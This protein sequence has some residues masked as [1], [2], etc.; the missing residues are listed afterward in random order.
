MRMAPRWRRRRWIAIGGATVAVTVGLWSTIASGAPSGLAISQS[1]VGAAPHLSWGDDGANGAA[2]GY[3]VERS[4]DGCTTFQ[5]AGTTATTTFDDTPPNS[6]TWCYHVIGHYAG[7]L[8][9]P[10]TTTATAVFDNAPPTVQITSPAAGGFAHGKVTITATAS[11]ALSNPVSLTVQ[12]VGVTAPAASGLVWDTGVLAV[13]G[14]TYTIR[15]VAIDAAGNTA[16]TTESV[17]VDN[18]PPAAPA[19]SAA[20]VVTGS[21]LLTWPVVAGETYTVARTSTTGPGPKTFPS[22]A[23]G[24]WSDP[25]T[26]PPGTYTYVVTAT[27]A[28]LNTAASPTVT[29]VVISPGVT[30]PRSLTAASPTSSVPHL[31]WQPPITFAVTS[32]EIYRDGAPLQ[33]IADPSANSFSDA[34]APQGPHTYAVQA[35]SGGTAG[36]M[37]SSVAVTYDNVPPVL[38]S[39]GATANPDGSVAITW[40]AATDPAPGSGVSTYVVRRATGASAPSD[41]SAGTGICTLTAPATGCMDTTAKSGAFYAYAVFAVDAAGNFTRR[42]ASAKAVDTVAPDPVTGLKVVSSD[43]TYV[44]LGW[45]VPALKGNDSDLAGFRV[46]LLRPGSKAP[47]NPGDGTVVCRNEDPGDTLCDS[48][49][50]TTG[51]KVTYAVYAYDGVPN[52]STPVLIS[53]V[54]HSI[55]KTPPHKPTNVALSHIGLVYTLKW[56][57]PRDP[58]LS[59]F[60]VTLTA[61]TT[62]PRPSVGRA[63]VTGRVLHA[64]FTL[65]A[66]QKVYVNL[67]ALDVTGN[68][69]RVSQYIVAPA[70]QK[71]SRHKAVKKKK[72]ATTAPK[73]AAKTVK[74]KAPKLKLAGT[75]D[76]PV[77]VVIA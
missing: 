38:A 6:G 24:T 2:T 10:S 64:T 70:I 68:Y 31:T 71:K 56:V 60:R 29:V 14:Q 59:K 47:A 62:A 66:G 77:T 74:K 53:A 55:D 32:W 25:D 76:R 4:N 61:K 5:V 18:T 51:K 43:R 57:S 67:F 15:A 36:D 11:D 41:A 12:V 54:P 13:S 50:L 19:V 27:D 28:A 44:R 75:K 26:L 48:L 65:T 58:D 45:N 20:P 39:A 33:A 30:A 34:T 17:T 22:S 49:N 37:S 9:V 1:H 7:P 46:L 16:T 8:D 21:P 42:E 73:T 35:L 3:T 40:P 52:Y 69:S 72:G 63:V 23:I